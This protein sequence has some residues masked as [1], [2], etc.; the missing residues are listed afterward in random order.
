MAQLWTADKFALQP[1]APE[2]VFF[3]H[4]SFEEYKDLLCSGRTCIV[5]PYDLISRPVCIYLYLYILQIKNAVTDQE[6]LWPYGTVIYKTED[7]V[8]KFNHYPEHGLS[9]CKI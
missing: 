3:S 9:V 6:L 2:I 8:G 1:D 4:E 5:L 7:D